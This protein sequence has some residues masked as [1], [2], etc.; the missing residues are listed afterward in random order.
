MHRFP[1]EFEMMENLERAQHDVEEDQR[2]SMKEQC[3][4]CKN[5]DYPDVMHTP[6]DS[7]ELICEDCLKW[8]ELDSDEDE[9]DNGE[10]A[11]DPNE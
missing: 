5:W 4:Q 7:D 1:D 2:E 10:E 11:G 8:L 9:V 3:A 6:Y